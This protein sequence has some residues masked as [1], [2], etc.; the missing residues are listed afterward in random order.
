MEEGSTSQVITAITRCEHELN[1]TKSPE[2]Q[3]NKSCITQKTMSSLS[4]ESSL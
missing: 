2:F 1:L 3:K 4:G